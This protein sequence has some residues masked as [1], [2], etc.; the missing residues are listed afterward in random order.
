[1]LNKVI[2]LKVN[3]I[4]KYKLNLNKLFIKIKLKL[5]IKLIKYILYI[6]L[7]NLLYYYYKYIL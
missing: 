7:I 6:G 4:I 1:M 5:Y 3:I 2:F